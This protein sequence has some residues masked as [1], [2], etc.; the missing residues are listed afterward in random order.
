M[1]RTSPGIP[2]ALSPSPEDTTPIDLSLDSADRPGRGTNSVVLSLDFADKPG[3]GT[4]SV[5]PLEAHAKR[6]R[7]TSNSSC[8]IGNRLEAA[9]PVAWKGLGELPQVSW[10]TGEYGLY[11]VIDL[12]AGISGTV[13]ALLALGIR[14]IVLAAGTCPTSYT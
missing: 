5:A 1:A 8:K 14:V 10:A 7:L 4:N 13:M 6:A 9:K 2:P 12:W 3:R 11:L